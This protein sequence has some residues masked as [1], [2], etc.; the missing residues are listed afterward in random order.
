M[1]SR[2]ISFKWY[3]KLLC[4]LGKRETYSIPTVFGAVKKIHFLPL[5]DIC[6]ASTVKQLQPF[7]TQEKRT[8]RAAQSTGRPLVYRDLP[9]APKWSPGR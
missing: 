7:R 9:H 1:T 3:E 8:E 6:W 4:W 2:Y 5:A